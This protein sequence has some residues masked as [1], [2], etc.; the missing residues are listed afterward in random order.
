M[1]VSCWVCVCWCVVSQVWHDG[2]Q[3]SKGAVVCLCCGSS[4]TGVVLSGFKMH[5]L[6]CVLGVSGEAHYFWMCVQVPESHQ[7]AGFVCVC[8]FYILRVDVCALFLF[9]FNTSANVSQVRFTHDIR[10]ITYV[11]K[12]IYVKCVS[13]MVALV[14]FVFMSCLFL[15]VLLKTWC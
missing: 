15:F 6:V 13:N 14:C 10:N 2:W 8:V 9:I 7:G 4:I 1:C 11:Y 3:V 5:L 12:Q